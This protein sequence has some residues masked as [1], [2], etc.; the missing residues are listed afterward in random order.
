MGQ[1]KWF[2]AVVLSFL[3]AVAGMPA[4]GRAFQD[5][6]IT[7]TYTCTG[8]N[9]GETSGPGYKGTASITQAGN[10]YMMS[11]YIN[12]ESFTGIGIRNGNM[13][14]VSWYA[15][16]KTGIVVYRING[17]SH[18]TLRAQWAAMG[19]N[20]LLGTETLTK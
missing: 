2:R 1:S 18:L 4:M 3:V 9:P 5:V 17:G 19:G 12:G 13:L 14:S 6:D 7:G 10:T 20:G 8:T 16:G 11:W 15:S